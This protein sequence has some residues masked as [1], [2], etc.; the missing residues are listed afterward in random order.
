MG[1][2]NVWQIDAGPKV[3]LKRDDNDATLCNVIIFSSFKSSNGR[4]W[5]EQ[6]EGEV[7]EGG[8]AYPN[9]NCHKAVR[10]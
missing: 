3:D 10:N 6:R 1:P 5:D 9:E 2:Q 4:K 8:E 7:R